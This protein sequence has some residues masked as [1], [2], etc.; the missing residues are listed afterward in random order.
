MPPPPE[1][2]REAFRGRNVSIS[3][4][5]RQFCRSSNGGVGSAGDGRSNAEATRNTGSGINAAQELL[6]G[7]SLSNLIKDLGVCSGLIRYIGVMERELHITK[8]LLGR[9]GMALKF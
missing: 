2:L 4:S 5:V 1:V 9:Q 6:G 7:E 3:N 8:L